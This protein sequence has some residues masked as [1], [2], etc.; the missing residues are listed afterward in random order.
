MRLTIFAI[1]T[2]LLCVAFACAQQPPAA[3]EIVDEADVLRV[4]LAESR[5]AELATK[6]EMA[7]RDLETLS[8]AAEAER[9][10]LQKKYKLVDG[11][12]VDGKTRAIKRAAKKDAKK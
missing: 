12:S 5:V 7:K 4:Q 9:A 3:V 10:A 8:K 6:I 1:A 11:D 2:M